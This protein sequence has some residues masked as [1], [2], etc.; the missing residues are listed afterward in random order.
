[1]CSREAWL[2]NWDSVLK[3]QNSVSLSSWQNFKVFVFQRNTLSHSRNSNHVHLRTLW[4]LWVLNWQ[5][6][7][8]DV[9]GHEVYLEVEMLLGI[10]PGPHMC[11]W[12]ELQSHEPWRLPVNPSSY[13]RGRESWR[14]QGEFL[15]SLFLFQYFLACQSSHL[16][17]QS[18]FLHGFR[19]HVSVHIFVSVSVSL[20]RS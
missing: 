3:N 11:L 9:V 19:E 16:T 6:Y 12:L 1:M 8:G 18:L 20:S 4:S 7:R 14:K 15:H 13:R 10:N 5:G 17:P 2:I